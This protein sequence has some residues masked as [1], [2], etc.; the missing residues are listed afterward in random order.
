[1]S[2]KRNQRKNGPIK[3][4]ASFHSLPI[5]WLIPIWF[6]GFVIYLNSL[7]APFNFDSVIFIKENP[8]MHSLFD[9][10]ALWRSNPSRFL[11]ALTF[12]ANYEVHGLHVFGYHLVNLIFHLGASTLAAILGFKLLSPPLCDNPK[13]T[14][15]RKSIALFIGLVFVSHPL[16][17]QAV[18]YIWQRS[19]AM[20]GFFYL[21]AIILFIKAR[22]AENPKLALKWG[23]ASLV[24][25]IL[26]MFTKENAFTLPICMGLVEVFFLRNQKPWPV[27]AYAPFALSLLIIPV[28]VLLSLTLYKDAM[29]VQDPNHVTPI[30]YLLSQVQVTAT[31][32]R[33]LVLPVG[34]NVDHH[35]PI[36]DLFGVKWFIGL[37][38][39]A[40]VGFAMVKLYRNHKHL[41]FALCWFFL[42]LSVEAGSFILPD[43][44]FEHRL[45]LPMFGFC[46]LLTTGLAT[47]TRPGTFKMPLILMILS[48]SGLTIQRNSVWQNEVELWRDSVAKSPDKARPN[49]NLGMALYHEKQVKEALKYL[50]KALSLEPG[51]PQGLTWRGLALQGV[52]DLD[53]ALADYNKAI[54]LG[55]EK[56][57][58]FNN[59]GGIY[60]KM[61]RLDKALADFEK[62]MSLD[63]QYPL[64]QNNCGLVYQK[65][66]QH[67]KAINLFT[68]AINLDPNYADAWFNRAVSQEGQGSVERA[69]DDYSKCLDLEP[70][71]KEALINLGILYNKNEDLQAARSYFDQAVAADPTYA[72]A[73]MNR[74]SLAFNEKD[75]E[76]ALRDYNK[77]MELAPSPQILYRRGLA[78]L[79]LDDKPAAARD[80]GEARDQGVQIPQQVWDLLDQ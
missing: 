28:M 47:V 74:G 11:V 51:N 62:A 31:Y 21:G 7:Q 39:L 77:L 37:I 19:T 33:L 69:M 34:Q 18:T 2:A 8:D 61:N 43:V 44:M 55:A 48:L 59:R 70:K 41:C 56:A 54:E 26:A 20:V 76:A 25:T 24:L 23:S 73:Y 71:R 1:M 38:I 45:Y 66:N 10:N 57:P 15:H 58:L 22:L 36:S 4:K 35:F 14:V 49:L 30:D 79:Y 42:L 52:G 68:Q 80:L 67:D 78:H 60:L 3:S 9:L 5:K 27:K 63:P 65:Q 72:A 50:N 6:V 12:A 53:S 32:L 46:L 29:Q 64:A 13:I 16:Q 40:G 75:Y 17:T